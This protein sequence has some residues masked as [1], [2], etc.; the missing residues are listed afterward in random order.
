MEIKVVLNNNAKLPVMGS[1]GAG[2]Y[3][4]FASRVEKVDGGYFIVHTDVHFEIPQG[5]RLMCIPRSSL[6]KTGWVLANSVGLLDSDYRGEL[7]FRF[8]GLLVEQPEGSDYWADLTD[9]PYTQ[10]D[11]I[12]Q[13]YLEKIN[14][15]EF[16]QVQE[17]SDTQRGQGGF[18][19][20]GK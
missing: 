8:R 10:G 7:Q 11:R 5:Y 20:T 1:E 14:Y 16:N 15:M 4:V 17:L 18:G 6:T 9:F 3:D 2:A 19:S 12:G 13:V